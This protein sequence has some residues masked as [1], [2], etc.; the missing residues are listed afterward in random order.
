MPVS[1][2]PPLRTETILLLA[3]VKENELAQSYERNHFFAGPTMYSHDWA[4]IYL[5]DTLIDTE[6]GSLLNITDQILKSW[7]QHGE[8]EYARFA[9][10]K[11][12]R[13][14][15]VDKGLM[16]F[17]KAD[18]VTFNWNTKGAGYAMK[19]RGYDFFAWNRTGALPVDYLG[20]SNSELRTAEET[21]YQYFAGIKDPNLARV[22]QYA[23]LYQIFQHYGISA[24]PHEP[25]FHLGAPPEFHEAL[26]RMLQKIR[27]VDD[28]RIVTQD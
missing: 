11:P 22:V 13:F 1:L 14:P 23:E 5:S 7:S 16:E 6:Y 28:A 21:G 12:S 20:D 10:P 4:P 26:V 19:S 9:Y 17:V 25:A 8:I 2:L 24:A 27:D 18:E 3:S 15:F